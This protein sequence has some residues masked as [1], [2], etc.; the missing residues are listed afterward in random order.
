MYIYLRIYEKK[1]EQYFY[2]KNVFYD[3]TFAL[4]SHQQKLE[5]LIA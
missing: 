1:K 5:P 4:T 3:K 2:I